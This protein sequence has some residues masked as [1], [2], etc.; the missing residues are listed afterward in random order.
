MS[1]LC[2]WLQVRCGERREGTR[3]RAMGNFTREHKRSS[4][5]NAVG[6]INRVEKSWQRAHL[7]EGSAEEGG[8]KVMGEGRYC[9]ILSMPPMKRRGLCEAD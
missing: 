5:G 6:A 8:R 2:V 7:E 3:T 9:C 1:P 4:K